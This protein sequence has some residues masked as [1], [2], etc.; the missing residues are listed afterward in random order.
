MSKK[1]TTQT[2]IKTTMI[3]REWFADKFMDKRE[4]A[5]IN[6]DFQTARA[7]IEH[8]SNTLVQL[9]ARLV[10][11]NDLQADVS[12]HRKMLADNEDARDSL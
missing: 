8:L 4:H 1:T 10:V 11:Q 3:S 6:I 12:E 9:N 5:A 2:T 7:E